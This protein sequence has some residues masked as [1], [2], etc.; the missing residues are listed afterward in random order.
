MLILIVILDFILSDT[1]VGLEIGLFSLSA[2]KPQ[3]CRAAS[4]AS[5]FMSISS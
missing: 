5:L 3:V 1:D 2:L 4:T